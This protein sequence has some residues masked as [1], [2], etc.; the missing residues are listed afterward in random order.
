[1]RLFLIWVSIALSINLNVLA[2]QD[3]AAF[4]QDE[5]YKKASAI[6][7]NYNGTESSLYEARGYLEKILEVNPDYAPAYV[8]LARVEYK[9]GYINYDNYK[10]ENLQQAHQYLSKA[11]LIAPELFE[12]YITRGYVYLFQKDLADARNMAEGAA[13]LRP[14]APEVNLLLAGIAYKEKKYDEAVKKAKE[15]LLAS[16]NKKLK[17][18]AWGIL[19]PVYNIRQ[20]YALAEKTYLEQ[21]KLDPDSAW[22]KINYSAFLIRRQNYDLAI[23]V[24]QAALRDMDLGMG[25]YVLA[26]AYYKKGAELCW[27]KA[28]YEEAEKAFLSSLEHN[29]YYAN[30]YYGLGVCY[31]FISARLKD[32]AML[33][34]S[35]QAFRTALAIDPQHELAKKELQKQ[36]ELKGAK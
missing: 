25:H 34:K 8:G 20:E 36:L 27:D 30:T 11:L 9:L 24:S 4:N 13:K 12:A 7:D 33:D 17:I 16:D 15:V 19:G 10:K 26:M 2:S 35:E 1:M 18:E 31:R 3:A 22:A 5:L 21:I 32:R 29:A 6:L 14:S 23:E 28:K